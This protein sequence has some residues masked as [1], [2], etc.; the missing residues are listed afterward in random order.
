[1]SAT[2]RPEIRT[3]L[4]RFFAKP[5]QFK[6]EAKPEV[7]QW[8]ARLTG[9][10]PLATVLPCWREGKVVDWYGFAFNDREFRA[11]GEN[12]TAF[13]GPS[14]TTFCGQLAVLD[15]NDPIDKAV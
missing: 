1:M 3:F 5:N 8:V 13:V 7:A 12:L 10:E 4:D 9:P 14:Y 6:L 2:V 15:P 11:L